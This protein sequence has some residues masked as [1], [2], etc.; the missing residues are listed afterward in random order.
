VQ[1][2]LSHASNRRDP[3]CLRQELVG[4]ASGCGHQ[5]RPAHPFNSE[6]ALDFSG[7]PRFAVLAKGGCLGFFLWSPSQPI[8]KAGLNF[9]P[10]R[11]LSKL[12]DDAVLVGSYPP[13]LA[14]FARLGNG[15]SLVPFDLVRRH[16]YGRAFILNQEHYQFR[17]FGLA[18]VLPDDVNIIGTFVEGLTGCQSHFFSSTQLHHDCTL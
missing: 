11:L 9:S 13:R 2:I 16:H 6:L 4:R 7:A 14:F 5:W 3:E 1:D 17:R 12:G 15:R 18:C 10:A 8:K